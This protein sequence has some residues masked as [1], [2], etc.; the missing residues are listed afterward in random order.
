LVSC[1]QPLVK[2]KNVRS[3][4]CIAACLLL[5]A[6]AGSLGGRWLSEAYLWRQA[7]LA[8]EDQDFPRARTCLSDYL[9]LRPRDAAAHFALARV[10]RRADDLDACQ[11]HLRTARGLGYPLEEVQLEEMLGLAQSGAL[12]PVEAALLGRLNEKQ[13]DEGLVLEALAKGYL[14]DYRV[15]EAVRLSELWQA[16]Q[17]RAWQP[18]FFRGQADDLL[19]LSNRAM[20]EYRSA[21]EA[22]PD[23]PEVHLALAGAC[24]SCS[25]YEEALG[26]FRAYLRR[27]PGSPAGLYGIAYCQ[28]WLGQADAA[29]AT[30]EELFAQQPEHGLGLLLRGHLASD[31][32]RPEEALA[33]LRRA[34]RV[35]PPEPELLIALI[36]SLRQLHRE[37]EAEQVQSQ[38]NRVNDLSRRL[39]HLVNEEVLR[40]PDDVALRHQV[41]SILLD[42][43]RARE[44]L[45]WLLS[46][47]QIDPHHRPSHAAL[48]ACYE[49]LGD[50]ARAQAHRRQADDPG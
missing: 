13:A 3:L 46:A 15:T 50:P 4:V 19:Q 42:L 35:M 34:E 47:L 17:P 14:R 27:R 45:R 1:G 28:H 37:D 22:A 20:D 40:R 33:W 16:R 23:R 44:A 31:L 21:L 49:Q 2:L 32:H 7:R 29:C 41:G 18:P 43:G 12:R 11:E 8:V 36:G 5:L 6:G 38:L 26:E 10:C 48:A 9:Q 39:W 24:L 30:L 25:R